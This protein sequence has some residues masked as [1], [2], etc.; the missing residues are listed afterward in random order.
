MMKPRRGRMGCLL[1]DKVALRASTYH[2]TLKT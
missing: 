2:F 1:D